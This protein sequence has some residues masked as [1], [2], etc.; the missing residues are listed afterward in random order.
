MNILTIDV[1]QF[2]LCSKN[3]F[4]W[5]N[6]LNHIMAAAMKLAAAAAATWA[7]P[8]E[9]AGAQFLRWC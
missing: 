7:R 2:V 1:V 5:V 8:N 4:L 6:T 3:A 9:A